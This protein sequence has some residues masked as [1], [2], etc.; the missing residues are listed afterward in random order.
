MTTHKKSIISM[1]I[2][3]YISSFIYMQNRTQANLIAKHT[4]CK[5]IYALM[6]LPYHNRIEQTMP[7]AMH[8]VKDCVEKVF[9]LI[10]GK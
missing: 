8:T 4:G 3:I 9:Y 6:R 5:G 7:D 10:T 1:C 2:Y